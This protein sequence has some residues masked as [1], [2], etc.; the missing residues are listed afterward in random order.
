M[1][2]LI[3]IVAG[4]E[5]G[6][7]LGADLILSLK[8]RFPQATFEGV[9]GK[10]MQQAGFKSLYPLDRLA[11]MG[12]IEPL[13]RLPEILGIRKALRNHFIQS[14]PDIF[15]GIDAPDFNLS[16]EQSLKAK[17]IKTAH[18]V[19]PTVWAWRKRRIHKIKKAVDLMLTLF[20]FETKIYEE[21]AIPV[22]C[23]GHSLADQIPFHSDKSIARAELALPFTGKIVAL[24]PGSRAQELK[25]L[26]KE[27]IQTAKWLAKQDSTIQF[28][29]VAPNE[30]REQQFRA[31]QAELN[32]PPIRIFRG[33]A[34]TVM[35]AAD[36][37]LC[38]SGTATLQAMLVKRPTVIAYKMSPLVFSIAKRIIKV[39][40]I[41]LP[42]LLA[43]KCVMPE[44]I[45][46][47][48]QPGKMGER[49]LQY[50]QQTDQDYAD[51]E[52]IHQLLK[53]N[54]GET[55]AQAIAQL[56]QI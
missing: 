37:I 35:A 38:A 36:A 6:D 33:N 24:L 45:Q 14:K 34:T 49:L 29:T 28:I 30:L 52:H 10:R 18:Y 8:Q 1:R 4:E 12:L 5:S 13:K 22:C 51:F 2:P 23:V 31:Y 41:G 20:P 21:H 48:V 55:S 11:V 43:E 17:G 15:I 19:S 27:F 50:L 25:Y 46:S 54:A 40:Y 42:N 16:L 32:G 39:P 56:I 26:A 7:I 9:G 44:F 53:K 47:D 3:G